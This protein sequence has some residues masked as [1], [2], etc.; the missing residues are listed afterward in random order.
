MVELQR[1]GDLLDLSIAHDDN[2]ICHGHG[3][4]LV[5]RHINHRAI[6]FAMK[7]GYFCSSFDPHL[8]I[9]IGKGFIKKKRLGITNNRPA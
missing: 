4:G 9:Q 2:A 3:L 5:M 6:K 8:G 7:F 1:S